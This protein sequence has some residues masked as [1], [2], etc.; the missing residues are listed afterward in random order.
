MFGRGE[1]GEE[2]KYNR[3]KEKVVEW[4]EKGR[5]KKLNGATIS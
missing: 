2:R 1:K 4:R 5:N 3:E